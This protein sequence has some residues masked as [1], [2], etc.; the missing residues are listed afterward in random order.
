MTPEEKRKRRCEIS[1]AYYSR[2]TR[3][4][5]AEN[6]ARARITRKKL[7]QDRSE[8]Q[9]KADSD[10]SRELWRTK[11]REAQRRRRSTPEGRA[12]IAELRIKHKKR[13]A[14]ATAKLRRDLTTWPRVAITAIRKRARENDL[15]FNLKPDDII[16]P[17]IC[18]VLG[19]P[20]IAG[21]EAPASNRPS[22]DRFDN[23]RGYVKDNIR[24]ISTRANHLKS[25][26][27]LD[28]LERIVKYMRDVN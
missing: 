16:V 15:E 20:L 14:K 8:E 11:N 25:N 23:D 6:L 7:Y 19:I 28:E 3:E 13:E 5:R 17:V 22:V 2:L 12:R 26:A 21:S 18:P 24:V 4:Q 27:T 9:C 10:R 1:A